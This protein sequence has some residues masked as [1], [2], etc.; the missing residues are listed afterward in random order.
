M[1]IVTQSTLLILFGL[2]SCTPLFSSISVVIA[3][4]A[5]DG[6]KQSVSQSPALQPISES[7][8]DSQVKQYVNKLGTPELTDSEFD[9]LVKCDSKA[10]PALK[11]ALNNSNSDVRASAAYALG[12]ISVRNRNIKA[13]RIIE[14][15][16]SSEQNKY[17]L[18]VLKSYKSYDDF[19]VSCPTCISPPSSSIETIGRVKSQFSG[20]SPVICALPGIRYILPRCR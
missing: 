14:N 2:L 15:N 11:M 5:E 16:Q 6:S 1:H 13:Y 18:A 12:E 7:C 4:T 20:F 17:V 9:S 3:N 8:S 10:I 19:P